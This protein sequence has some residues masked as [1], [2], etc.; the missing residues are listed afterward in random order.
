MY[1]TAREIRQSW[2]DKKE[3]KRE[4]LEMSIIRSK[5]E[6]KIVSFFE[7]CYL[8]ARVNYWAKRHYNMEKITT[9]F[10]VFKENTLRKLESVGFEV[11]KDY[12]PGYNTLKISWL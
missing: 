9:R 6:N 8:I 5:K 1:L 11:S 4:K 10:Y 7:Y 12:Y 3:R 2:D